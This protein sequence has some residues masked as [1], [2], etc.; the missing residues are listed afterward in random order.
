MK[1][2]PSLAPLTSLTSLTSLASLTPLASLATL[3]LATAPAAH[4][5]QES[6][7]VE[8]V[9]LAREGLPD[10][11]RVLTGRLLAVTPSADPL[12]PELLY[13]IALVASSEADR[14]LY[15]RRVSIEH[16]SST[17]ADNALL[18]LA[19][20]DYAAGNAEA[21]VRHVDRLLS[22]YPGSE[23]IAE[24]AFWG[25]RAAFDRADP[26]R[27][28]AWVATGIASSG[29]DVELRNRLEFL[30]L[31][32]QEPPPEAV[33]PP[34]PAPSPPPPAPPPAPRPAA[35]PAWHVQVAAL[36]EPAAIDRIVAAL[37]EMGFE[38][39]VVPGPGGLQKVRAGRWSTRALASAEVARIRARF[40]GQPFVVLDP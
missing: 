19:Q 11:A 15:L 21:T 12:Y 25:G 17:W 38:P 20:M 31:R 8:A 23:V 22:D 40:G 2:L 1:L 16:S 39:T 28:C 7:L 5:Q 14:R 37:R 18:Q 10:S 27:A 6:R 3:L 26:R 24:A 30:N 36:S 13:T 34:A 35:G 32:C 4:A 9:R 33:P 29:G